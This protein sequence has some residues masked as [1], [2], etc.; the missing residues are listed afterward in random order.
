MITAIE[1]RKVTKIRPRIS[2]HSVRRF[3]DNAQISVEEAAEDGAEWTY[4]F[5][6][7]PINMYDSMDDFETAVSADIIETFENLG[8]KVVPFYFYGINHD[9]ICKIHLSWEE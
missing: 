6:D 9:Y 5:Y 1:A 3:F 2:S 8:Y 7:A 4:L